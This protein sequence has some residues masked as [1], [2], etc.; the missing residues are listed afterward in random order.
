[1]SL[2][3]RARNYRRL[4][5]LLYREQKETNIDLKEEIKSNLLLLSVAVSKKWKSQKQWEYETMNGLLRDVNN[6][7]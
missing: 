2:S 6:L 3:T 4:I 7:L 1:M 5:S